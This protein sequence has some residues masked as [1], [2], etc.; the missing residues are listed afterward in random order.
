MTLTGDV[1]VTYHDVRTLRPGNTTTL[2]TSTWL[3]TSPRGGNRFGHEH[4]IAPV[5]DFL[6]APDA[7]GAFLGDYEGLTTTGTT[8]PA[9]FIT[10]NSNQP[11]NRTD[12]FTA[13]LP[14]LNP[15]TGPADVT[16]PPALTTASAW[17]TGPRAASMAGN[18][19]IP[20]AHR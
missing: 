2:P 14:T 6:A 3:T 11:N 7:G 17:P 8:V 12:A 9:L 20:A 18:H 1:A 13:Q 4:A 15:D 10:S 19:L 16:L 5:F